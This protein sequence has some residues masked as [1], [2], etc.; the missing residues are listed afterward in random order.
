[1]PCL[2]TSKCT[3]CFP[4]PIQFSGSDPYIALAETF[5]RIGSTIYGGGQVVLPMLLNEVVDPGWV[6]EE[7]FFQGF[8]LMQAL[9]GPLFNISVFLGAACTPCSHHCVR[10][11]FVVLFCKLSYVL[12]VY[13]CDAIA[14]TRDYLERLLRGV[15]YTDLDCYCCLGFCPSGLL[16]VSCLG[17]LHSSLES[18]LRQSGTVLAIIPVLLLISCVVNTNSCFRLSQLSKIAHLFYFILFF[19]LRF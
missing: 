4:N 9:P 10:I 16:C 12:S 15:V 13:A 11:L 5:Y 17:S 2:L 1:M 6:S 8:A 3:L 19:P 7:Q 18:M 14:Q